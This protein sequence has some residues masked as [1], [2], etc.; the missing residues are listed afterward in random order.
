VGEEEVEAVKPRRQLPV[1]A[2][3]PCGEQ[4]VVLVAAGSN[5][6][7]VESEPTAAHGHQHREPFGS[8]A[9]CTQRRNLLRGLSFASLWGEGRNE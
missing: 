6:G 8:L 3:P 9:R 1:I 4:S 2:T 5:P 7:K